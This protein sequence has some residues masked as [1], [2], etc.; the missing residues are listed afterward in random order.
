MASFGTVDLGLYG[1]WAHG[2]SI[3]YRYLGIGRPEEHF[4]AIRST[5][6]CCKRRE[7]GVSTVV[8]C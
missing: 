2:P 7:D 6:Q 1:I 4:F 8:K 3:Y 5:V